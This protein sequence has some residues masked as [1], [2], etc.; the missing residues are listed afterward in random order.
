MD[1]AVAGTEGVARGDVVRPVGPRPGDAGGRPTFS[2]GAGTHVGGVRDHNEDAYF[3][4]PDVC[5]VADGMG[6]HQAGE[7][8]S[9]LVTQIV[10][11]VFGTHRLDVSELPRFVSALNAAVLRKGAANNTRGMG[12]TVVGVAVADNGDAPSAVVFHVGDSRCYRLCN[13]VMKQLTSDHSHVEELVQAGRITAQEAAT[14]PLR[15]VITRA[16]GA[17]VSVQADFHVLD[18]EDCRIL[19]CSDGLSGE[20][21]D[22]RIW[23][24]L[25]SHTDPTAAAVALID[26]VLEGPARDNVTATVVDVAFPEV[27]LTRSTAVNP[28]PVM[29]DAAAGGA[30]DDHTADVTADVTAEFDVGVTAEPIAADADVT[31]EPVAPGAAVTAEFAAVGAD[32]GGRTQAELRPTADQLEWATSDEHAAAA[33]QSAVEAGADPTDEIMILRP[34][35]APDALDRRSESDDRTSTPHGAAAWVSPDADR[36]DPPP[37]TD[38]ETGH[39]RQH[40]H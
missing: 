3:V 30:A 8:A 5:V 20:I 32:A 33:V 4:S 18:D 6:G 1:D 28:I 27:D 34:W 31:A 2:W 37:A 22:D 38:Q 15:N 14:H 7:V 25:T 23:D 39:A 21:D 26:A 29:T 35:A 19:L 10:A 11:D 36:A 17:D 24:L 13:G 40:D 9:H 12:T 16:L